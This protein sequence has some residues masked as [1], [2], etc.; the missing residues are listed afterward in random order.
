M[1][2]FL[3][4]RALLAGLL[5]MG[6]TPLLQ[7]CFTAAVT[8]VGAG[9]LMISDRR[10]SGAYL[11]DESIEWKAASLMGKHFGTL[12][13]INITS[14]NRNVL[15]T[16]EVQNDMVRTE[17]E[18][19]S[20]GI[21]NVRFVINEL[22]VSRPS[23]LGARANDS[24]VT[25]N[26]KAR[27]VDSGRFAANH[28]K[29]VTEARV[30]FL[31]GIVTQTEADLAVAIASRSKGV[32]NVVRVFEYISEQDARRIDGESKRSDRPVEP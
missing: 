31:M 30:V 27:F 14:Y 17:A 6:V 12:N 15:L 16:G 1:N 26:V 29:V 23:S 2:P 4:R 18:R 10:T 13:H 20:K 28:V 19:L 25:S 7:G 22:I 11:E 5:A 21:S 32:K 3:P 9:A 24:L 8:G